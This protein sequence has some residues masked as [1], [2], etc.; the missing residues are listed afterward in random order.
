[1]LKPNTKKI[2]YLSVDSTE[3]GFRYNRQDSTFILTEGRLNK[4][5]NFIYLLEKHKDCKNSFALRPTTSNKFITFSSCHEDVAPTLGDKKPTCLNL[6]KEDNKLRNTNHQ[7]IFFKKDKNFNL[8]LFEID[9]YLVNKVI[10]YEIEIKDK[11]YVKISKNI[12]NFDKN[13]NNFNSNLRKDNKQNGKVNSDQKT[14]NILRMFEALT[15][16]NDN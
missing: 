12:E 4:D 8:C 5:L 7:P 15:L 3:H 11:N 13:K 16:K 2:L 6:D 1:M 14:M 9:D 10:V